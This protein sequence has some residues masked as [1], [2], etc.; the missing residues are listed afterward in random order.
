MEGRAVQSSQ[1]IIFN[2]IKSPDVE[3]VTIAEVV[4]ALQSLL[5][6]ILSPQ[7]VRSCVDSFVEVQ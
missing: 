3:R 6:G 1:S 5:K 7:Q 2:T 4:Q